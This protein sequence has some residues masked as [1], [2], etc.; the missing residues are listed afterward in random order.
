MKWEEQ[1]SQR[2]LERRH[3][4]RHCANKFDG[5]EI[6]TYIS[7]VKTLLIV[8]KRVECMDLIIHSYS[9]FIP[10]ELVLVPF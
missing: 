9:K 10:E 6:A 5:S 3:G 2:R 7:K 8:G 1:K 4:L